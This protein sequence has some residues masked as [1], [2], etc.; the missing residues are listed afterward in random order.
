MSARIY[1]DHSATRPAH[2]AALAAFVAAAG[3]PG[4]PSSAHRE[5]RAARARLEDARERIGAALGFPGA[6][7]VLTGSGSEACASAL[8]GVAEARVAAGAPARVLSSPLEHA[9]VREALGRLESRGLACPRLAVSRTGTL[10]LAQL[11][12]ELTEGAALVS[13][14]A[15]NNELGTLLPLAGVAALCAAAEVPLHLDGVALLG[16][17]PLPRLPG[18]VLWSLS[19][20]KVG[21]LPGLGVLRIPA[22]APFRPVFPGSQE[23]GRRAG[24]ESA[25]LAAAFAAAL[26]AGPAY[27]RDVLA[28]REARFLAALEASHAD[29][30]P[31]PTGE[32]L[33]GILTLHAPRVR[34]RS[35][36]MRLDLE[37][38]AC[39]RGAACSSGAE[40]SSE[41]VRGLGYGEE[42][43][44]SC[45]RV[46]LGP[47]HDDAELDRAA[48]IIGQTAQDLR[49]HRR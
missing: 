30:Q 36:V 3:L 23:L 42:V 29:V 17:A 47:D 9:C 48:A 28:A 10:D 45:I 26:E 21:G 5:G 43:A 22:G 44:A 33:P 27:P 12:K 19:A 38:V 7:L 37:G 2:P 15:L 16:R 31:L 14:L 1:L 25:A 6:E 11:E 35:W 40:E 13:L 39:S 4:N 18:T 24:T 8:Y 34:A 20:H 46:S 41:V 32:R 49:R